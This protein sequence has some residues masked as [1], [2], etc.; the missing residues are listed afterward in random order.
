MSHPA[1]SSPPPDRI[2]FDLVTPSKPRRRL[3][4][5]AGA[6]LLAITIGVGLTVWAAGRGGSPGNQARIAGL[7]AAKPFFWEGGARPRALVPLEQIV[8]G[9]PPPDGIPPIDRPRFETASRVSWLDPAEPVLALELAGDARAY[10]IQILL[11]HEIANDTV[12]GTPVAVTYCPL[13]NTAI[14]YERT[15]RGVPV[16]FGT[17]GRLYRSDLVMYDRATKTLWVQF[18]G[19]GVV[20]PLMGTELTLVPS[21]MVSWQEF[22]AAHPEG[23]VL[24]RDTGFDRPYGKT[25]YVGYD[26]DPDPFLFNGKADP[27]LSAIA[28]VVGVQ[29]GGAAKAYPFE[30][31]RRGGDP[32]VVNDR[33]GTSDI[34]VFF[35]RAQKSA[36]DA[37]RITASR[38]V[39]ETG[40]FSRRLGNRVLTFAARGGVIVDRQTR[41]TW[42]ILGRASAGPLKG[43]RLVPMSKVDTFWFAWSVFIPNAA[44]WSGEG[45]PA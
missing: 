32:A 12:G 14:T 3:I 26:T 44:V 25:P 37:D 1:P 10:P 35:K 34:V 7:P 41:S 9:G 4:L 19:Q 43:S 42:D 24:S 20:G 38:D 13:C 45:S 39:G 31:L 30:T 18:S 11:W 33:V 17:S 23:Q 22:R 29:A 15:V 16:T 21:G 40:V 6:V 2:R 5:V 28:R 8:P 27:R 36:L